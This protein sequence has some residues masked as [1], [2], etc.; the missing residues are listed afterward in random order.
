MRSPHCIA[1]LALALFACAEGESVA[2]AGPKAADADLPC[3]PPLCDGALPPLADRGPPDPIDPDA[4][5]PLDMDAP[6]MLDPDAPCNPGT[7]LG[8]C[9]LCNLDGVPEIPEDDP[10]CPTVT[11][12]DP[13]SYARVTEGAE[14]VCYHTLREPPAASRCRAL[15]ECHDATTYCGAETVEEV[16]RITPSP[17]NAMQGCQGTTPPAVDD[18][19]IGA[20]CNGFGLCN[21]EGE[22]TAPAVC[23]TVR[24]SGASQYCDASGTPGNTWCQFYLD[25]GRTTCSR[26]CNDNGLLCVAA[27][28]DANGGCATAEVADCGQNLAQFICRCG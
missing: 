18:S 28:N 22:C 4:G 12:G 6:D 17:C 9:A 19:R 26:F 20:P 16:A 24:I 5:V 25:Q 1:L 8:P 14:E 2:D 27:W 10:L 11:C 7:R 13:E 15:G 21:V 23:A 3:F